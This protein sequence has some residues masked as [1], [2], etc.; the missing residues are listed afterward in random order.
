MLCFRRWLSKTGTELFVG[1]Q[2]RPGEEVRG[3]R[4]NTRE[5]AEKGAA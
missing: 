3:N 5:A 1:K 2:Y 4:S